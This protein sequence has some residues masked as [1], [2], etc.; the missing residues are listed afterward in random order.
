MSLNILKIKIFNVYLYEIAI[1]LSINAIIFISY[2]QAYS[3]PYTLT[4]GQAIFTLIISFILSVIIL[5][6]NDYLRTPKF[7]VTE[8]DEEWV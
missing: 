6:W 8:I 4:D 2:P 5:Y 1:A 3:S 7:K